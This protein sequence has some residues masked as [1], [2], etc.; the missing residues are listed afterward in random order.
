MSFLTVEIVVVVD[1][2]F[3]DQWDILC[4]NRRGQ[5]NSHRWIE[6]KR[7]DGDN[8]FDSALNYLAHRTGKA[9]AESAAKM[10]DYPTEH[11]AL[12]S[13][14]TSWRAPLLLLT[15]VLLAIGVGFL[16]SAVGSAVR[17]R[18]LRTSQGIES[19]ESHS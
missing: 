8:G 6:A 12:K 15:S 2:I 11:L 16:P 4:L 18:R 17:R 9:T 5:P 3:P 14:S 19:V 13:E 10:I 1:T 7:S